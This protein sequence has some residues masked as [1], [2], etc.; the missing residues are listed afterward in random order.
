MAKEPKDAATPEAAG[1]ETDAALA[2]QPGAPNAGDVAQVA[3]PA[4]ASPEVAAMQARLAELEKGTLTLQA[5]AEIKE[6]RANLRRAGAL[7]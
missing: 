4:T 7:E 6:L 5:A 1:N 2:E 3:K